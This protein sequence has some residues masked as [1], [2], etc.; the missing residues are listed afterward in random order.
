MILL[1]I[2]NGFDRLS[3]NDLEVK[4]NSIIS[5][6]TGNADFP[7]PTPTLA[8]MQAAVDAYTDALAKA[9]T[10]SQYEKAFKNQ[11]RAELIG[12]LHRLGNY[13]LFTANGDALKAKSS[14]F[15]IA[16]GPSPSPEV[17]AA[18]NQ[19][20]EDGANP[21]E[22]NY[23][24]DRVPGA[25]SYVY[26]YTTDPLTND[27]VW[28]NQVGTVRK[29]VLTGLESGKKYWCRV[30]AIGINGQGIYSEPV[31]RLVQ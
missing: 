31:S 26:Q 15:N 2:T 14:G 11:K 27:S 24:F 30:M 25:R 1:R 4:A 9:K 20:L 23:S 29:I 3:D 22:L 6:L 10:G 12:L 8:Q 17:T 7:N 19:K 16:K 18:T 5:A 21:G 13:V 28:K